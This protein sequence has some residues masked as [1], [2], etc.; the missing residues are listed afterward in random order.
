MQL[1]TGLTVT[2][3]VLVG[4][5]AGV[6][7]GLAAVPLLERVLTRKPVRVDWAGSDD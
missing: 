4:T 7:L 6:A 5:V 1:S 3:A 2:A